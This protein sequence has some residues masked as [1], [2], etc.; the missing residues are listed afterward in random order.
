MKLQDNATGFQHMGFPTNN[1]Q[2]TVAFYEKLGFSVALRTYNEEAGE[3]VAFLQLGN[4]MLE[5][6]ENHQAIDVK[7]IEAAYEEVCALG[8]N[9]QKDTIHFLPFWEHG[10]KYFKITGPNCEVIEFSQIL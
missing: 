8:L 4:L 7:D 3:A 10:V 9:N 5:I 6:Y 2:E 1:L